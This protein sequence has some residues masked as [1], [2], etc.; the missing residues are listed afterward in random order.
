MVNVNTAIGKIIDSIQ[1]NI[2][3]EARVDSSGISW[4]TISRSVRAGQFER[5]ASNNLHHGNLGI[6][7]FLLASYKESRDERL[8]EIIDLALFK[9]FIFFRKHEGL[10]G[11]YS[12]RG[13]AIYTLI[14]AYKVLDNKS[15]L[16]KALELGLLNFERVK[17]YNLN[18][19]FSGLLVGVLHLFGASKDLRLL[20]V[21]KNISLKI[22]SGAKVKSKGIYW[23]EIFSAMRPVNGFLFGNSGIVFALEQASKLFENSDLFDSVIEEALGYEDTSFNGKHCNWPDFLNEDFYYYN[24][25]NYKKLSLRY[26]SEKFL[27]RPGNSLSWALGSPGTLLVRKNE[28]LRNKNYLN[29]LKKYISF[30][31]SKQGNSETDF[32]LYKGLGGGVLSLIHLGHPVNTMKIVSG[33]MAQKKKYKELLSS[34]PNNRKYTDLSLFNGET[35]I[36]YLLLKL[37]A[38]KEN[39]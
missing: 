31:E 6:V 18:K 37:K 32:C 8:I 27:Y 1:E 12:G 21:V 9:A 38:T 3:H 19:G 2:I 11:F 22:I 4:D 25:K 14:E 29:S 20:D 36:G 15:Y 35:G 5:K 10:V 13:G 28:I 7:L 23:D 16:D 17:V 34:Y 33:I 26:C 30:V 24:F 39:I